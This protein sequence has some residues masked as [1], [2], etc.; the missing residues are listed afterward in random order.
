MFRSKFDYKTPEQILKMRA[1]GLAT[2]HVL[3]AIAPAIV[4]GATTRSL[5]DIAL[6]SLK[7]DGA[8]ANFA[9]EEDY[10]DAI[11]VSLNEQVVHGIPGDRVIQAG[12]IVSVD[13]GAELGGWNGDSAITVVVPGGDPEVQARRE[14]L[15]R[16]T[17]Q[18]MWAGIAALASAKHVNEVGAAIEDYILGQG[19]FGIL[20]EYIGHGIGRQMHEEP[21]VFN[22]AI[23]GRG[24]KVAPGLVI[25]IEPMVTNGTEETAIEADGWAISTVD[26]S[27]GSHWE[28]A[29]AVTEG[30][31]WVL[32]EHDGGAAGLAPFGVTPA[33][34]S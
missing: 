29:V 22:Y 5:D 4:P 25:C 15:N 30:G 32:T 13:A 27:D 1:A 28:N 2:R 16:V 34:L 24:A 8:I 19:Q 17:E 3:D 7:A 23:A 31:V 20:R 18:S 11:C 14:E 9:L 26:G 33:P 12:D 21:P 6:A 10:Y